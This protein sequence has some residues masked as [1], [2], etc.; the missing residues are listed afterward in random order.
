LVHTN[1]KH[2]KE[3]AADTVIRWDPPA[4]LQLPHRKI[5]PPMDCTIYPF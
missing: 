5:V 1:K 3:K 4:K 2:E